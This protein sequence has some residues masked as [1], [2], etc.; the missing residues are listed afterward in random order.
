MPSRDGPRALVAYAVGAVLLAAAAAWALYLVRQ[1]LVLIYV[2]VLLAIGFSPLIR[3][4]ERQDVLPVGTRIPRWLAIL[5]VY[6]AIL[7][8]VAG[9]GFAIFPPF[10]HQAR[11]FVT[12]LPALVGRAEHWLMEHHVLAEE[13]SFGEI[14]QQGPSGSDV[15]GTVLFTFWGLVGGMLGLVSIVIL[16]FYLLVDSESVFAAIVRLV[17]RERRLRVHAISRQITTKVSA[18]LT[19]QLMLAG[20]VGATSALWLGLLGMPY[21]YVLALIAAVGE[22]I[23][24]VGPLLAAVPGIGIAFTISWKRALVVA[25]LYLVQQQL[26]ANILVP[27]MMERQLGLT[28]VTIMVALLIGGALLGIPGAI[29]AVPSAAILQVLFQELVGE[30]D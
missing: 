2:S 13:K 15:V 23:P 26:E 22:M 29:L 9:I 11:E 20:I 27:K 19:G 28:P 1:A 6:V 16:T 5:G 17:P 10:V 8:V 4:I 25:A 7:G 24:I 21:F 12:Q 18:W 3:M 30:S 14:V